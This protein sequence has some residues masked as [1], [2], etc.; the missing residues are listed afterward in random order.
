MAND[1]ASTGSSGKKQPQSAPPAVALDKTGN[2]RR[3]CVVSALLA[4]ASGMLNAVAIIE[5]SSTVA[6]HTGNLSHLG[7]LWGVDSARFAVLI[8]SYCVGA[9][10]VGWNE[11]DGDAVFEGRYS[12]G[13]L[14]SAGA[15]ATGVISSRVNGLGFVVLPLWAFSQGL[16]NGITSRFSSMPIRTTHMTGALTDFG[17]ILGQI[18]RKWR[19]GEPAPSLRKPLVFLIC[20]SSFAAG[21]FAAKIFHNFLGA[22]A[23]AIPAVLLAFL[24]MGFPLRATTLCDQKLSD[25]KAK[26]E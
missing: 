10:A 6:H 1:S 14:C 16:Q 25:Q 24:A 19:Y 11:C 26:G 4:L 8:L 15:I 9:A 18:A 7:R 23:G 3:I 13:L 12:S 2:F 20:F 22:S 21:G 17:L 5:F